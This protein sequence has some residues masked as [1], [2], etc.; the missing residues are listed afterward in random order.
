MTFPIR[1]ITGLL[2]AA[3]AVAP[4]PAKAVPAAQQRIVGG[5]VASRDYAHQAFLEIHFA[6]GTA[7]CAGSLV[8][9]RYVVTAAHCLDI[10]GAAPQSIEVT[11]GDRNVSEPHT[12]NFTAV[13]PFLR[14][15]AYAGDPSSGF[16]VAVL[17]LDHA[18]DY[19]QV[20]LL[21]TGETGMWAPGTVATVI[22]WGKTDD[23]QGVSNELLEV[24]VPI[25]SDASCEA[26]FTAAGGAGFVK[27]DTMLCAGGKDGKDACQG[28]SGGPLLVPDGNRLALAG[29][30]SWGAV[31]NSG[32]S[33]AEGLPG[34]YTRAAADPVNG[35]IRAHVP[36]VEIDASTAEP[37]PGDTVALTATGSVA[38]TSFEWDLDNDGAFDDATGAGASVTPPHG[39]STVSVRATRGAASDPQR[40]QEVRRLDL[41]TRHRS[42]VGFAA[43][44]I[45]VV[46]G[47]AVAVTVNKGG[48]GSGGVTL[49]P[50][51]GTAAIG[52]IDVVA[53]AP[54]PIAFAGDQ[55]AQTITIPTVDDKAVEPAEFFQLDLGGFTGELLP[56]APT[57]IRVTIVDNDVTPRI[58]SSTK[59]AK[60]RKGRV[61]L[62]YSVTMPALVSIRLTDARGR[63]KYGSFRRTVTAKGTYSAKLKL[64]RAGL[65]ALRRK[66]SLKA[67]AV[68]SMLD[69]SDLLHSRAVRLTL[70]R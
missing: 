19:E 41:N 44:E 35:W 55:A 53:A 2:L 37:T 66:R 56:G 11:L 36:Q 18:A 60:L 61:A 21:R 39:I 42:P 45:T 16:D 14:H 22:G 1:R 50:S 33:C 67:R 29:I 25:F 34:V 20:R 38:Y 3:A 30:V 57:Q 31:M 13:P 8:A 65:R 28:D 17:Q 6:D 7:R 5:H 54:T 49:T 9:A 63:T 62:R 68:Y 40:D 26:D 32:F 58:S 46:E 23:D 69:G 70:K 48:G 52:G 64:T 24:Q 4:A 15:P 43:P 10:G 27:Y 59:R 51:T 47:Q 12:S